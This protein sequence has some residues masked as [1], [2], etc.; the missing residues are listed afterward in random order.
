MVFRI[1][2][3]TLFSLPVL[4]AEL[5]GVRLDDRIKVDGQ[6]LQLNGIALRTRYAFFNVYVA[7]LYLPQKASTAAAAIDSHG[8]KRIVLAMVREASADQ[9]LESIDA[10]LRANNSD[11]QLAE[12][13]VQTE[14]LYTKIRGVREAR[15]GMRIVLDYASSSNGTTLFVDGAAQGGPMAGEA[16]YRALLRI[17]LGERPVQ[18][19][20]KKALLGS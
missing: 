6:E 4:G 9:F 13:K 2:F 8:A 20:L 15:N 5:E 3:L 7:G 12:I 1:L 10:G 14:E 17:W 18:E 16:F 11:A 19:D